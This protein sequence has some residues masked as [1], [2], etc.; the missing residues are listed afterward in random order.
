MNFDTLSIHA[1]HEPGTEPGPTN[2]PITMAA[3]YR[4]PGFGIKLFDALELASGDADHV[5]T[6][7]SN[8]T[9]R[10]LEERLAALEGAE[11]GLTF[12]SGM[13]AVAAFFFTFLSAGHH[14]IANDVCY[15]GSVEL[16]ALHM[17]R[18]GVEVSI[19]DTSDLEQI[20][21][22][23]RPNTRLIF[24][25]TPAN[26]IL[27]IADIQALADIAHEAGAKLVVDSTFATPT[28]Q[29]PLE[30]GADFVIHSLTKYLNGHGDALGGVIL[31][32]EE[33]I[34]QI[35]KEMLIHLG[36]ALSPFN[37]W[38]ILRGLETLS[39]RMEKHCSN[40][41]QIAEF[42]EGHPD[43]KRV[44]YP[45]LESHPHHELAKRQM[46]AFGGMVSFQFRGG[47]GAAITMAEK[48]KVATFATSLGHPNTL[49]FFYPWEMY[50]NAA[51][52]LTTQQKSDIKDWTGEGVMRLSVGLENADDLI[53]D[54]D[55]AL[56]ARTF[57]GM[58]GSPIY[59][60]IK[61]R[62]SQPQDK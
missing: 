50:I 48:T 61:N 51:A 56:R 26:P 40:A 32:P 42:L 27:R 59:Q 62:F 23:V 14:I 17:T 52:Y 10:T 7:W 53:Q 25:E 43:V 37:A 60:L 30:L 3:T 54:L 6:R 44:I 46:N 19:V 39:M 49:Y 11:A 15:A 36:G 35:R 12:A 4:L 47:I 55:Q 18:F 5:Y 21:A 45:G 8:P 24:A 29:K 28:L 22:A 34:Q 16:L 31:G 9:L 38:L 33:E 20:K 2:T 1:G 41:M 57:K 13:A 58:I